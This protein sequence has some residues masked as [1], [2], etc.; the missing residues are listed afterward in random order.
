[1]NN[2]L[3][4]HLADAFAARLAPRGRRPTPAARS[5]GPTASPSAATPTPTS[6]RGPSGVVERFGAATLAR[7][8]FN[9]NEFLYVD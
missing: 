7:A 8:L 6:G 2:A 4:L 3:V 5:T 9:S 1:M